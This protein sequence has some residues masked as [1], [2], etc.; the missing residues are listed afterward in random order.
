MVIQSMKAEITGKSSRSVNEGEDEGDGDEETRAIKEVERMEKRERGRYISGLAA[1][2]VKLR[3]EREVE[4]LRNP[5]AQTGGTSSFLEEVTQ[6]IVDNPGE[7]K[8]FTPEQRS[9]VMD[10]IRQIAMMN[11]RDVSPGLAWSTV[12]QLAKAQPQA[13]GGDPFDLLSKALET[14]EKF[15]KF[16]GSQVVKP[17]SVTVQPVDSTRSTLEQKLYDKW[18]ERTLQRMDEGDTPRAVDT[19]FQMAQLSAAKEIK[20]EEIKTQRDYNDQKI[21]EEKRRTDVISGL[22]DRVVGAVIGGALEEGLPEG[23]LQSN[24][25]GQGMEPQSLEGTDLEQV[26]CSACLEKGVK[27]VI[28]YQKGAPEAKCNACGV[29]WNTSPKSK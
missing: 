19:T 25:G 3:L 28:T 12:T 4:A 5:E 17:E 14:F 27:S 1:E 21:A 7:W 26:L 6:K 11:M 20:L 2:R 22:T 13:G 8:D 24:M 29:T 9:N 10:T 16:R 18:L 15:D 23:V